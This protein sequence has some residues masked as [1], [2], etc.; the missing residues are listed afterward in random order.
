MST[1]TED[2]MIY[3]SFLA[4]RDNDH[5]QTMTGMALSVFDFISGTFN[6]VTAIA[7]SSSILHEARLE[8]NAVETVVSIACPENVVEHR[9]PVLIELFGPSYIAHVTVGTKTVPLLVDTGS[10]DI[11]VVPNNFDCLDADS[12]GIE[13]AACGFPS[14][15]ENTFSGG[16]VPD[17]Y[18]SIVYGN[19]QFTHGPYGIESITL[20]GITVPNQQIALPSEGY[21]KVA[22]GDFSGI[23]GLGYPGMV[24]ARAG[25]RPQ[26]RINNTDPMAAYD[27]WFVNAVKQNLTAPL[28]SMAL[29]IEGGGLLAIGGVVDVPIQ[30]DFASTAI[31]VVSF[32]FDIVDISSWES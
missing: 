19:G 28:F 9:Q 5:R 30:G 2:A 13:Q 14:Y 11:W 3:W 4:G 32:L 29:E 27:T 18:L 23:F 20:G 8:N 10:S 16:V 1:F 15:V 25:K 21:I 24:A 7:G 31:L 12:H 26:A 6:H 22:S 17:N